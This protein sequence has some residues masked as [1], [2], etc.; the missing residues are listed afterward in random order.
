MSYSLQP[1]GLQLARLP[2]PSPSPG[3]WSTSCPLSQW[4]HPTISSSV[5]H[6]SSC[7]Q[8]LPASGSFPMTQLFASGGQ[9]IEASASVL[10][11]NIQ[12]W[13]PLGLTDFISL[14]SRGFSRVFASTTVWEHSSLSYTANPC[15]LS[16]LCV[17]I[18]FCLS[19]TPNL[20]LPASFPFGKH[21][22]VLCLWVCLYFVYRL[23]CIKFH[24]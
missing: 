3:A 17:V 24:I 11:M 1:H 16:I 7:P 20:S 21:K 22:F 18:C 6:F 14:L 5:F 23:I 9:S 2:C 12:G 13:F 10:P 8:S 4:C 15:C 19:H